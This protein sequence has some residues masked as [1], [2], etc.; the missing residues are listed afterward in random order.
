VLKQD[1]PPNGLNGTQPPGAAVLCKIPRKV[2]H[3]VITPSLLFQPL[4]KSHVFTSKF[5]FVTDYDGLMAI[6]DFFPL[7]T[8]LREKN[9]KMA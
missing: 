5:E 3:R 1:M 2:T 9:L 4:S 6:L 7:S 8:H